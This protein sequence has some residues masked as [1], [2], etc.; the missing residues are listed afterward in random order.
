MGKFPA[1]KPESTAPTSALK[2]REIYAD[3][4][5]DVADG[6][7]KGSENLMGLLS[8]Y[9]NVLHE[10]NHN[11]EAVDVLRRSLDGFRKLFGNDHPRTQ[12]AA[13]NLISTLSALGRR[14]EA[15]QVAAEV[16]VAK[17]AR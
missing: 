4:A 6:F 14:Q 8:N 3:L 7:G 15:D 10:L 1:T 12:L 16:E 2:S 9:G 17:P 13:G 5:D 11:E